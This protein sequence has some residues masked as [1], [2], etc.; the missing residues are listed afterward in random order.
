VTDILFYHLERQN[1]QQVLPNLLERSVERGWRAVVQS[2]SSERL[3]ALDTH[4]WTYTADS[5]LAHGLVDEFASDHP[6]LLT[7]SDGNENGAKVRFLIDGAPLPA[8]PASYDRLVVLFD[9]NDP[10]A[11]AGARVQWKE[12][13]ASGHECQYWQQDENGRWGKK[14]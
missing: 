10:E 9:G 1:L 5:F 14:G 8:D 13:K 4:L 11:V 3:E 7:A 12:A 2:P 6:I